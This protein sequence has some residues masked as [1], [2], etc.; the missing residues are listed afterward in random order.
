MDYL[1]N[2]KVVQDGIQHT[3]YFMKAKNL[4]EQTDN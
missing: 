1:Q 3:C 2:I 4:E